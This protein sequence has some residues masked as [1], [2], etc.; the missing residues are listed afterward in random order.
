MYI[1]TDNEG[2]CSIKSY[3]VSSLFRRDRA[4]LQSN[5]VAYELASELPTQAVDT[6]YVVDGTLRINV[7][8][9]NE[10]AV[11]ER[12]AEINYERDSQSSV[13]TVEHFNKQ[14]S[15]NLETRSAFAHEIQFCA[16]GGS[17][18]WEADEDDFFTSLSIDDAT[19]IAVKL[20]DELRRLF[21]EAQTLKNQL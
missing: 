11:T 9:H 17:I 12:K 21:T 4:N 18:L 1:I 8:K 3:A 2:V 10:I 19:Q 7:S 6:W 14:W 20:R 16:E 13:V 5:Q 15:F